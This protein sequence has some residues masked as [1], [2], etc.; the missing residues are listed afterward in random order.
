MTKKSNTKA[1][2]T[3]DTLVTDIYKALSNLSKGKALKIS[4]EYIDEFGEN[5]KKAVRSWAL[6]QKQHLVLHLK[7]LVLAHWYTMTPLVISH[8]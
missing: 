6:P 3:L 2:L 1:N 5:I 4:D 8:S 7:S